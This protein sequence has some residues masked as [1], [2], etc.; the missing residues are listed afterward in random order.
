MKIEKN[1]VVTMEYTL[2]D[3]DNKI[4]EESKGDPMVFICGAEQII[5]ALEQE[6]TGKTIGDSVSVSVTAED[7]YGARD[8]DHIMEVEKNHLEDI[9]DLEV[10]TV[11]QAEM[12]DG[13]SSYTVTAIGEKTVTLDGN[14][15][16]AGI[17]LKFEV[18][19]TD[20]RAATEDE[21]NH[22]HVH[23]EN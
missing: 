5:P 12:E 11:V 6:I 10:G 1:K 14:H 8:E 18:K 20:V 15:P 21:I 17:P 2:S 13:L 7:G 3:H 4:I 22:G 19:I 16:L 9:E 23:C